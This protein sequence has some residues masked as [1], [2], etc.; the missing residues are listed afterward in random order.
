MTALQTLAAL[1]EH[2]RALQTLVD[3]C[4]NAECK[5]ELIVV[6]GCC[7]AISPEDGFLLVTANQ[8]E[9]A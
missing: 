6:A 1:P 4:E 2:L 3:R 9:T 5:K 7:G 8:L